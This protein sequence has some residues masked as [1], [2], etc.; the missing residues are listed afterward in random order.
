[1]L[2]EDIHVCLCLLLLTN[3][4]LEDSAPVLPV[5]PAAMM[6]YQSIFG[7]VPM[8]ATDW[9]HCLIS[10]LTSLF[11]RCLNHTDGFPLGATGSHNET[12]NLR[13]GTGDKDRPVAEEEM[14]EICLIISNL[15]TVFFLL[16]ITS[17]FGFLPA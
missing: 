3:R 4:V 13:H 14:K 6:L 8:D 5:R 10:C 12:A 1:M 15:L 11:I 9:T 16:S 7:S 2:N 17:C